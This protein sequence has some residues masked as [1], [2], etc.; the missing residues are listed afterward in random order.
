MFEEKQHLILLKYGVSKEAFEAMV[1]KH[2]KEFKKIE[3][4][5]ENLML[6]AVA[7]KLPDITVPESVST[8]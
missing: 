3:E 4:E 2:E 7:G 5:I 1:R 6:D 8:R